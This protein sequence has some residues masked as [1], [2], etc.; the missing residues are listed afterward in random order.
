MI[1]GS[2]EIWVPVANCDGYHISN[3]GRVKSCKRSTPKLKPQYIDKYGYSIVVLTVENRTV[4]RKVHRLVAEAF[5]PNPDNKPYIN[6]KDEN[7]LNNR[8]DNLEWVTP[9]ENNIFGTRL[10]RVLQKTQK[11]VNQYDMQGRFIARYES[12]SVAAKMTNISQSNISHCL[13]GNQK[14]AGG[15]KWDYERKKVTR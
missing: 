11:V 1:K 15:Y 14:S 12:V 7:K 9:L 2:P 6:H 13:R 10:M 3:L 5:I 4:T 8:V